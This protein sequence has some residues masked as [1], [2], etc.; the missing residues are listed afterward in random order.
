VEIEEHERVGRA[1]TEGVEQQ[2]GLKDINAARESANEECNQA[3][4]RDL[5][6]RM[7]WNAEADYRRVVEAARAAP[8]GRTAARL[9]RALR[10]IR[11]R[12]YFD[13]PGRVEAVRALTNQTQKIRA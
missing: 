2:T 4:G 7:R 5:A 13:A 10:A 8:D 12:D 1:V 6:D 11:A 3:E 9:R